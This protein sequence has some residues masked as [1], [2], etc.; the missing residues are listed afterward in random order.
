MIIKGF[1]DTE[2]LFIF[3]REIY[4]RLNPVVFTTHSAYGEKRS[5]VILFCNIQSRART[6]VSLVKGLHELLGNS[7]T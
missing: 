6:H 5:L 3:T 2:E 1:H 4:V 7:T